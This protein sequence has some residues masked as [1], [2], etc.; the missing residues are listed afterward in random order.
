MGRITIQR[1]ASWHVVKRGLRILAAVVLL[2]LLAYNVDWDS[3][4]DYLGRIWWPPALLGLAGLSLHFIVSPWK[5]QAA[6]KIHDLHFGLPH[7]IRSNGIGFFFNN[8]LPSGIGGD[9]YRIMSTWPKEGYRSRAVS[10]VV[11]E[12]IVGFCAL[13]ALGNLG[14]VALSAQSGMARGFILLSLLGFV[15]GLAFLA[16]TYAGWLKPLTNRIR[17]T[18]I[19]EAV[20]HNVGY[21]A[22][23]RNGWLPLIAISLLF[24]AL[25]IASI[26]I[27]FQSLGVHVSLASCAVIGAAAGLATVIPISINGLGVVEG[28]FAGTAMAL[29][30]DYEAALAVAV[31]MRLM[32]LPASLVFG[33]LYALG[34]GTVR[35][36]GD[37]A[38]SP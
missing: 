28:S 2:C 19:F 32:V 24:Q 21:L 15:A 23:A 31:L 11:I 29:G 14:A 26:F 17:H 33:L 5:W 36:A 27:V 8:F 30:V 34:G 7:L 16:A 37:T 18:S 25:A 38:S 35:V 20:A 3:M 6:L 9:A 13:V 10:A 12:R 22:K 1:A 4:S